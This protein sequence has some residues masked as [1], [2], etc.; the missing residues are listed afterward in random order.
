MK[1]FSLLTF[2]VLI[3]LNVPV[4]RAE[5]SGTVQGQIRVT[6]SRAL[7]FIT[8]VTGQAFPAVVPARRV[9]VAVT[10]IPAS[11]GGGLNTINPTFFAVTDD[12]GNFASSWRDETRNALPV[13]LRITV[14]WLAS[15]ETGGG[16]VAPAALFRIA[17]VGLGVEIS[18]QTVFT[19]NVNAAN[20][21]LGVLTAPSN[22]ETAAYLTTDEFFRRIVSASQILRTRMPGLVVRT[23]V[24]NFNFLFGVAPF[25]REVLVSEGAP[26]TLPLI[27]AHELGHA[28]T[29]AALDLNSAPINPATDYAHPLGLPLQW[30]QDSREFSKAAFLE[31]LA[32]VWALEWAFGSDVNASITRG[33]RTFRYEIARVI[34]ADGTVALDC[35]NVINAH[36]FPF[37]H[38]AAV[39]DLLDNDGGRGD[40][41]NLTRANIIDT[42][43]RFQNCLD[44]GCRDELGLDALNHHDFR[45][46]AQGAGRRAAIRGVWIGN[47]INGGPASFCAP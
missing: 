32:D 44:N 40:G 5:V 18:P 35:R 38:T 45:C 4:A 30:D 39:R 21:N 26:L 25:P 33:T 9:A 29:W 7:G 3:C 42:L 17:R 41:V 27:L 47:G 34:R 19:R 1:N 6:D 24:P 22:D 46:N 2:A 31:G 10:A 14:M 8:T 15:N 36:E 11:S 12:G 28:V 13:S 37:C 43:N 16:T 23:R 20:T